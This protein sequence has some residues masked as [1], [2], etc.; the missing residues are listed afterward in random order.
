MAGEKRSTPGVEQS[1]ELVVKKP[2]CDGALI[3]APGGGG[4]LS[5]PGGS[6]PRTSDLA[7]PI[8][9]LSGHQG[10][11]LATRFSPCGNYLASA[12]F[13][14]DVLLWQV[15]GECRNYCVLRSHHKAVLQLSWAADSTQLYSCSADKSL[16]SWDAEYGERIQ[17]LVGHSSHVNS[18][19]AALESRGVL[20]S[21]CAQAARARGAPHTR[22]CAVDSRAWPR[23]DATPRPPRR[24]DDSTCR[25]WDARSRYAVRTLP[26][27]YACTAVELSADGTRLSA[28]GIDNV[29]RIYDLRK[30]DDED[31]VTIRLEGH[32]DT[33]TGQRA[34]APRLASR[35][36]ARCAAPRPSGRPPTRCAPPAP[37][38]P[39]RPVRRPATEPRWLVPA[40]ARDGQHRPL[41]GR[42]PVRGHGEPRRQPLPGRAAELREEPAAVRVGPAGHARRGRLV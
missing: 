5:V 25:I 3:A 8:M 19:S 7:A 13:D 40:L 38:P 27:P 39:G 28:G 2:R 42:P 37:A 35:A 22:R 10:E 18:V 16:C 32:Q 4:K 31:A 36:R 14:R 15:F 41:V 6:V 23:A 20:A 26:Q 21:G 29:V 24:S 11:V 1:S 9:K 34:H 12:G 33:I 30:G 17:R